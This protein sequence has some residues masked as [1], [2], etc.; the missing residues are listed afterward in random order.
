MR[1][2]SFPSLQ[3]AVY[4]R[5][6]INEVLLQPKK[7]LTYRILHTAD[8]HLGKLL[9]DQS[10]DEEHILFLDWLIGIIQDHG[11]D[12]VVIAGDVF[13]TASPSNLAQQRY[14]TFVSRL[15]ALGTCQLVV[16]G[17]NH[18]SPAQLD[19]P[20]NVLKALNVHVF[21]GLTDPPENRLVVLP[22]VENP[23]IILGAIPFLRDRDVRTS[24]S[25][26]QADD[27]RKA[28]VEGIARCYRDTRD[29]AGKLNLDCPL[30]VTGHLTVMGGQACDSEREIHIGGLGSV[31]PDIF[32]PECSA[33]LLGHL[34]RPQGWQGKTL[35][36][37]SG[38]P[39]P[40]SFSES[41]DHK[42]VH[43]LDIQEDRVD[44]TL[45]PIPLFRPLV[46]M[47]LSAGQIEQELE[48]F[49]PPEAPLEP[50]VELTIQNTPFR[51]QMV[52]EVQSL[53]ETK[54]YRIMKILCHSTDQEPRSI[55]QSYP[56]DLMDKPLDIFLRV[57]DKNGITHPQ[58]MEQ[59]TIG[60]Q[61][62]LELIQQE[63]GVNEQ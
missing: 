35:V 33:V 41:G 14:F 28:L 20:R 17:G 32:P 6:M 63:G 46:R 7:N 50:W 4:T 29:A 48:D 21:G 44:S 9:G 3:I 61:K 45:V 22:S 24:R 58:E 52:Q 25:G 53:T 13:D 34:H 19:A 57:L 26:E 2:N 43:V 11:I 62:V 42:S 47:T 39:I 15:F 59:L 30:V 54:P 40:L 5:S 36:R 49:Q 60:F 37:Y 1:I 23:R 18:D 56:E 55:P 27:I 51:E 10:R 38:S 8:W 12:C 16:T 31:G